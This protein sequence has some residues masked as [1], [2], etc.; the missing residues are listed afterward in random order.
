M[1]QKKAGVITFHD[2]DNYGAILQSYALQQKLK[3]LGADAEIIDYTCDYISNPFQLKRLK[4]KGLFNYIYGAIGY[5]CY[6]PRRRKC[7]RFRERLAYSRHVDAKTVAQLDG[8]YDV[9]IA[10]SDQVWDWHLTNFDRTYLLDFVTRGKKCSYAASMGEHLPAEEYRQAYT[11]LLNSF[12]QITMREDYGAEVVEQLIGQKPCSVCDPTLLLTGEEWAKL[13]PEKK[14]RKPYILVYQ[15]GVNPSFVSF[16]KRMQKLTGLNVVYVPFPLVGLMKC[17]I[18]LGVGPEEWIGL[19]RDAEYVVTDSFHG[20]VFSILF[21][22]S[23]FVRSDGH[24]KNRRAEEFLTRLG[25]ASR[26][27]S[28]EQTDEELTAPVDY[29]VAD[30]ELANFREA[31][32]D[33]LRKMISEE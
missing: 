29:A 2:Y 19:F 33:Q 25:L 18:Q 28:G 4:S 15:L 16:V 27:I 31:S 17:R 11:E 26:L 5:I 21:H 3:E 23:F 20:A 8:Q 10:G 22:K 30:R 13:V 6:L 7:R 1:S 24:H 12:D 32:V 14:K 9:F